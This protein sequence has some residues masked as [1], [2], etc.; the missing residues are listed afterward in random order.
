MCVDAMFFRV[1]LQ[2][3][4]VNSEDDDFAPPRS[5]KILSQKPASQQVCKTQLSGVLDAVKLDINRLRSTQRL[6]MEKEF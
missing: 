5:Q 3:K 1:V 4:T 6:V 2:R